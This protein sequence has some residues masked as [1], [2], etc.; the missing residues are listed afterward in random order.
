MVEPAR[1]PSFFS[2]LRC[3]QI[4][5]RLKKNNVTTELGQRQP[6]L[7]ACFFKKKFIGAAGPGWRQPDLIAKVIFLFFKVPSDLAAAG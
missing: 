4:W 3:G 1:W 6:D 5:S 7:I 2:F